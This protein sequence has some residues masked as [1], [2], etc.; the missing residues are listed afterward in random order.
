MKPPKHTPATQAV[1][2]DLH[3]ELAVTLKSQVD[4]LNRAAAADLE[5]K[6]A[7]ATL[8]VVRQFLKDNGIESI[9]QPGDESDE[10]L[11]ALDDLPFQDQKHAA[12]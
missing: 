12:H 5:I 4:L 3:R 8:N 1:L 10:L 2:N 7:A 6:G 11:K 9:P